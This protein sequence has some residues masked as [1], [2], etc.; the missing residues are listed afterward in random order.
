[1]RTR[2]PDDSALRRPDLG[3]IARELGLNFVPGKMVAFFPKGFEDELLMKEL[4]Y[5]NKPEEEIRETKFELIVRGNG[6]YEIKV[7]YQR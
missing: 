7:V 3:P 6:K 5:Q 2:R 4:S 1:M